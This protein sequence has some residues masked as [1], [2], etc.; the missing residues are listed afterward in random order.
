MTREEIIARAVE[1]DRRR[2]IITRHYCN[3]IDTIPYPI[4]ELTQFDAS[5]GQTYGLDLKQLGPHKLILELLESIKRYYDLDLSITNTFRMSPG[6]VKKIENAMASTM[7]RRWGMKSTRLPL[8]LEYNRYRYQNMTNDLIRL[9]N[10]LIDAREQKLTLKDSLDDGMLAYSLFIERLLSSGIDDYFDDVFI[11]YRGLGID[12]RFYNSSSGRRYNASNHP[13]L[14]MVK[15]LK[16][17]SINVLSGSDNQREV[18]ATIPWGDVELFWEYDLYHWANTMSQNRYKAHKNRDTMNCHG[19]KYPY[20]QVE[21]PYIQRDV[22]RSYGLGNI[23]FGDY[24]DNIVNSLHNMDWED[25]HA[26]IN[27]WSS[28]YHLGTTG[29]LNSLAY[30]K[31]G[32]LN[33]Y[34]EDTNNPISNMK[35]MIEAGVI[36]LRTCKNEFREKEWDAKDFEAEFCRNCSHLNDCQFYADNIDS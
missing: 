4:F 25:F 3:D 16:D 9:D 20:H 30:C 18:I 23:C 33:T 27:E 24:H 31:I 35:R 15:M 29:P 12:K 14:C 6:Y 32:N 1:E 17:T 8:R 11:S 21:H 13:F 19:L 26:K 2:F 36:A 5:L 7:F 22:E 10:L 28:L 34:T